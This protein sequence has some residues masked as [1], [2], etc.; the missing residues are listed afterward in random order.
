MNF[1]FHIPA[2]NDNDVV[3]QIVVQMRKKAAKA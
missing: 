1:V 2:C 3:S